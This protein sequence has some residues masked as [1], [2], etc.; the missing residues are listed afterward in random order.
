MHFIYALVWNKEK[1]HK[2]S[3][4]SF[5]SQVISIHF[6]QIWHSDV[7]G[8]GWVSLE[9]T[10]I[11]TE[12]VG[13]FNMWVTPYTS[14]LT[15]ESW[16]ISCLKTQVIRRYK[17]ALLLATQRMEQEILSAKVEPDRPIQNFD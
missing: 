13:R 7:K 17:V 4:V 5:M 1:L 3:Y 2:N 11:L 12:T 6:R 14:I 16:N 8:T 10:I 9:L 15:L